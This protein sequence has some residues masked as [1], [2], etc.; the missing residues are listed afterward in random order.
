M[1][2]EYLTPG[3]ITLGISLIGFISFYLGKLVLDFYPTQEDKSLRYIVGFILFLTYVLIPI[4][5]FYHFPSL[6]LNLSWIWL[7]VFLLLYELLAYYFKMKMNV[8]KINRGKAKQYFY[9]TSSKN[10]SKFG[11]NLENWPKLKKLFNNLFMELPSQLKII[12]LGYIT[13]F[14]VVNIILFFDNWIIRAFILIITIST[15]N[16][17][18]ILH[19]AKLINYEEV[20]VTDLNNTKFKGRLIKLDNNYIVLIDGKNVYHFPRENIK[21]IHREIE[22]N[23]ERVE[24]QINKVASLFNRVMEPIK[25][26]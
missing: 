13:I 3:W 10:I 4:L 18:I 8:F 11:L 25:R 22:P 17:I 7:F 14:L 5:F 20:L 6:I 24:K 23:L 26:K 15:F 12:I 2:E 16:N 1:I 9:E 21:N 19:N